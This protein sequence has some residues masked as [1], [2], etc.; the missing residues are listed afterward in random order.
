MGNILDGYFV[1]RLFRFLNALGRN[2]A[3]VIRAQSR[4]TI[5]ADRVTER[6]RRRAQIV[7]SI[8]ATKPRPE[9]A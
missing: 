7:I 5:S 3:F 9:L 8:P 4:R 1:D 6:H 2:V